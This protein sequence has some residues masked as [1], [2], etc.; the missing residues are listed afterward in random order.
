M[1]HYH[2][3]RLSGDNLANIRAYA[4]KHAM[5][6]FASHSCIETVAEV[7][8]SFCIDNGAFSC[9]TR[10]EKFDIAAYARFIEKWYRHPACDWYAIPDVIDGKE[11]DNIAMRS[12]WR[13]LCPDRAWCMGVP[14]WHM[15]ES[16]KELQYLALAHPRV[17]IGSSGQY[18]TIGNSIWWSRISEA[19]DAIC[20]KNGR[21]KTKLHGMRMLDP[22]IFSAL[23]LSSADSTNVAR[24]AGI[25]SAWK[26]TYIPK[27]N[28]TR[29]AIMMERI[30]SHC[31]AAR[32]SGETSGI[33]QNL[34][35]F[36]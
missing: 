4:G 16:L 36:G 2:G 35:L 28:E 8:Q 34:G 24:N 22:T 11:Q 26:G 14:V 19:M 7:C 6:S 27:S 15:H 3:T 33:Q 30:E 29:A 31:S 32:W 20:D 23:P 17:A 5:V 1:I 10:G 25:D 13:E 9:W 21:P 12:E 18:S